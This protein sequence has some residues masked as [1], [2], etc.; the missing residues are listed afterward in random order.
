VVAPNGGDVEKGKIG[1]EADI[2]IPVYGPLSLEAEL[3]R[4]GDH[5][6]AV[7][8]TTLKMGAS[9]VLGL[10]RGMWYGYGKIGLDYNQ[11]DFFTE[12][13]G[14]DISVEGAFG[15]H[16]GAGIGCSFANRFGVLFDFTSYRLETTARVWGNGVSETVG[17]SY[18]HNLLKFAVTYRF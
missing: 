8:M 14:I 10:E 18:N 15:Q 16:F 9:I 11:I 7:D 6:E 17:G 5:L 1:F 12:F 2:L 4:F 3:V 13:D